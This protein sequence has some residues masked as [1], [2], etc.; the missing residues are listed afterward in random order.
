[1]PHTS[2]NVRWRIWF[3]KPIYQLRSYA[4]SFY[5]KL[6]AAR[7]V[8]PWGERIASRYLRQRGLTI[9]KRNW[10]SGRLEA[11]IIALDKR[12]IAIIEVKTRHERLEE[13]YPAYN[14]VTPDKRSRLEALSRSFIRNNGPFFRRYGIKGHQIDIIEVYYRRASFGRR[15]AT[16]IKWHRNIPQGYL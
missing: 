4:S 9:L 11:D 8:G 12:T 13:R 10:R 16:N 7:D 2:T 14:A 3:F 5:R 1:M 15:V 6:R